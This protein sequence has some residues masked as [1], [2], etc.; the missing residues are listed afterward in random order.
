[1]DKQN[2]MSIRSTDTATT[3][4]NLETGCGVEAHI[5]CD[6]V[7]VKCPERANP[8][9]QKVDSLFSSGWVEIRGHFFMSTVFVLSWGGEKVLELVVKITQLVNVLKTSELY[10]F[11]G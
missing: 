10:T 8:Q 4:M 2:G 6:F 9:R 7:Y 5:L 3:W 11:K 1:M